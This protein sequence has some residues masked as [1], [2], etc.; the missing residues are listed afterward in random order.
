MQDDRDAPHTRVLSVPFF[1]R[2]AASAGVAVAVM[3]GHPGWSAIVRAAAWYALIDGTL[4][5]IEG[6][7]LVRRRL[8]P[9]FPLLTAMTFCDALIRLA[10]GILLL[11][12]PAIAEVPMTLVPL[13]GA[14]GL[15][16]A[17]VGIAALVV[18]TLA[19]HRYHHL[20]RRGLAALFDPLATIGFLSLA[21]GC[22]LFFDPP[23]SATQLRTVIATAGLV[24]AASF[25]V[26]AVG[27]LISVSIPA[28]GGDRSRG[29]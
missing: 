17:T 26:S 18:W 25:V 6:I 10:L 12:V 7:L 14:V 9:R 24:L 15:T 8:A 22:L 11:A 23:S 29:M 21:V 16:A 3:R 4:G 27:A 5:L 28:T 2:G 1:A 19:L 20:H 13:F